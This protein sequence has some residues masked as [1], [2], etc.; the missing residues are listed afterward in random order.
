MRSNMTARIVFLFVTLPSVAPGQTFKSDITYL[1]S[2]VAVVASAGQ[3]PPRW[4]RKDQAVAVR[5]IETIKT[6]W[7]GLCNPQ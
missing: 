5:L 7:H 3:A 2:G 4:G 6:A 1:H